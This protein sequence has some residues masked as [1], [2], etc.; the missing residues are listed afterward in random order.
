MKLQITD[1]ARN[2]T[3][4][5]LR[6]IFEA[7][8]PVQECTIVVDPATGKSKGFGFIE[9]EKEDSALRAIEKTN[10]RVVNGVKMKVKAAAK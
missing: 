9:M 7:F 1:L 10:G 4:D 6:K 5:D 8:A 2:L 3:E